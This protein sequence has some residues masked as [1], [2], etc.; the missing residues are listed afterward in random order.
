MSIFIALIGIGALA[1]V[2]G[3]VGFERRNERKQRDRRLDARV[4]RAYARARR[5]EAKLDASDAKREQ[6]RLVAAAQGSAHDLR[7]RAGGIDAD[8]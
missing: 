6:Q 2:V 3:V 4:M 1:I 5:L 7:A 8:V